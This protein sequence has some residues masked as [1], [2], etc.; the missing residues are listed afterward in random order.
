MK[1]MLV[2]ETLSTVS[3]GQKMT[4]QVMDLLKDEYEFI[5]LIPDK[6][7]L[8][9]AL[10]ERGIPY[11]LLG[12]QSMPTGVKGKSVI[13]RYAALSLKCVWKSLA[14]IRKHKPDI[15]YAP[16][17]AA[18]PWSAICGSL[19]HKPVVW[20]LHHIFL[21]GATKK[22][23]NIC[24]KW[25]TV[26]K[27]IAVSN[28]VGEQIAD[29]QA[30][31]KVE[32]IYNP[33]DVE[34]YSSG[35]P[36]NVYREIEELSGNKW[37]FGGG[38]L[39]ILQ[40]AVITRTKRQDLLID[41]IHSLTQ[42]GVSAIGLIV[43]NTVSE[44]DEIYQCS[45]KEKMAAMG[46]TETVFFL[47]RRDD[48]PDLLSIADYVF[49]P[50]EEGL[51]LAAMEAMCA[52]VDVISN[53]NGGAYELLSLAG[54]GILYEKDATSD[55]IADCII[56]SQANAERVN[57]GYVFCSQQTKAHYTKKISSVFAE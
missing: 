19:T 3:G 6:G 44:D 17:P 37:K 41:T 18:L 13:F 57:N 52:K 25:K 14:A 42:K 9:D 21:D 26:K 36:E 34:K 20:H 8:S 49:V 2:W 11:V 40:I 28:V 10:D 4:L 50:S 12:D 48:V 56:S 31:K 22:L 33:V 54:C 45:L 51:S 38:V 53:K 47:G 1:K 16:G 29:A 27:I 5:C 55:E 32:V 7:L 35:N 24:S 39:L 43:G 15:L 30:H 46:M 23:L